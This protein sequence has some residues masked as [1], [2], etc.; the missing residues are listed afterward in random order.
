MD[1]YTDARLICEGA[2]ERDET[3]ATYAEAETWAANELEQYAAEAP[4]ASV[5]I[6]L[7]D[8]EHAPEVEDC[9]CVQYLTDHHPTFTNTES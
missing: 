3:F 7:T 1:R 9:A 5:E 8:H 2:V 6:Y 4:G